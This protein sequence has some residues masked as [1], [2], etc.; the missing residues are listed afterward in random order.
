MGLRMKS[1]ALI[2]ACEVLFTFLVS[3]YNAPASSQYVKEKS[4]FFF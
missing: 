4:L 1:K 2:T 3:M